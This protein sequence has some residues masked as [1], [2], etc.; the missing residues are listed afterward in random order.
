M[1]GRLVLGASRLTG[2]DVDITQDRLID[3]RL[4]AT[5]SWPDADYADV[6]VRVDGRE[7]KFTLYEFLTVL[8]FIE[9]P[10]A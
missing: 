6:R 9:V 1:D 2:L 5:Q 8:G 7:K 3:Y 4:R 10:S